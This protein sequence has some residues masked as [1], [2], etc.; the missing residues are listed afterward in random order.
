MTRG[1]YFFL[2]LS[3]QRFSAIALVFV[4]R[5][6]ARESSRLS[7]TV[8]R[9]FALVRL[10]TKPYVRGVR[11]TLRVCTSESRRA[12]P[13]N[14]RVPSPTRI[15]ITNVR[16]S[17]SETRNGWSSRVRRPRSR[18]AARL[19]TQRPQRRQRRPSRPSRR[20]ERPRKLGV[21][22]RGRL[23]TLRLHAGCIST[24]TRGRTIS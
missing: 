11:E 21:G 17:R 12:Q 14:A 20:E 1:A 15:G 5:A 18:T 16:R 19:S 9:R 13:P 3:S 8:S 22:K 2:R 24:R 23:T 7:S 10:A 4:V 6:N